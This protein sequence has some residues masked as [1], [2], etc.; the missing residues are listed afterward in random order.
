MLCIILC[1]ERKGW[2]ME[3][4]KKVNKICRH[5]GTLGNGAKI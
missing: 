5:T 2:R 1:G 4:G 3:S